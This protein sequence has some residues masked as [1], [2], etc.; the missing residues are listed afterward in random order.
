M[1]FTVI[2]SF[3]HALLQEIASEVQSESKWKQLGELAM[4]TGNVLLLFIF[5]LVF[6]SFLF[7]KLQF[8]GNRSLSNVHFYIK[9]FL[10]LSFL[11]FF[12]S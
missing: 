10:L 6:V 12:F 7:T 1:I 3:F 2:I 11:F 9:F 4:S 8:G 5:T